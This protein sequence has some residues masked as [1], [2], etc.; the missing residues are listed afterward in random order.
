M[1]TSKNKVHQKK[2]QV[3]KLPPKVS[4]ISEILLISF[5]HTIKVIYLSHDTL[6]S[7]ETDAMSDALKLDLSIVP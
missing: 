4:K 3:L 1:I 5:F 7:A 6:P 2:F